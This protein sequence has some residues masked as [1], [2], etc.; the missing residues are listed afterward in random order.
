MTEVIN[1]KLF[2]H[3]GKNKKIHSMPKLAKHQTRK[4]QE[5]T[6]SQFQDKY[7]KIKL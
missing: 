5:I 1:V 2:L 3:N 6:R 7:L 4:A